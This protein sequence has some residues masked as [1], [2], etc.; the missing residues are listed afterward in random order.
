MNYNVDVDNELR[1]QSS[2]WFK[3]DYQARSYDF[4]NIYPTGPI[5]IMDMEPISTRATIQNAL[6]KQRYFNK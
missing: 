3:K 6:L 4:P 5:V 2:S 1:P